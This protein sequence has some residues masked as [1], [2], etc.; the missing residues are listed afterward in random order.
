M[1]C[2]A[3]VSITPNTA[4]EATCRDCGASESF[5]PKPLVRGQSYAAALEW[6]RAH[7]ERK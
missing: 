1:S 6:T 7:N 4:V 5:D 2:R 3:Y